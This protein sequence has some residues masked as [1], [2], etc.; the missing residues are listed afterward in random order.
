MLLSNH[1]CKFESSTKA[2][3]QSIFCMAIMQNWA[4]YFEALRAAPFSCSSLSPTSHFTWW[5]ECYSEHSR[6]SYCTQNQPSNSPHVYE[7]YQYHHSSFTGVFWKWINV[8]ESTAHCWLLKLGYQNKEVKKGLYIDGHE[9]P[10]VVEARK[11]YIKRIEE[12]HLYVLCHFHKFMC[13]SVWHCTID[14]QTL[15]ITYPVLNP[16]EWL[17][18]AIHHDEM[19]VATNEQRRWSWLKDS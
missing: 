19:S 16:G 4:I 7:A 2:W 18:I 10:D 11:C 8:S 15:E 13:L 6:V 9:C 14:E 3:P 17:H 12:F 1:V 5:W